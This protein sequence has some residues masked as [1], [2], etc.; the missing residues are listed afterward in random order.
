MHRGVNPKAVINSGDL[1]KLRLDWRRRNPD[2]GGIPPR[3]IPACAGMTGRV[4]GMTVGGRDGDAG[5]GM[6]AGAPA[7]QYAIGRG[8]NPSFAVIPRKLDSGL[9]RDDGKGAGMTVRGP[10]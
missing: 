5:A 10:G 9:R 3:E 7:R 8:R 4:A 1:A 2:F 6:A